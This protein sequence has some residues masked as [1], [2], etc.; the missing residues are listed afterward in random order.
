M[1]GARSY[2]RYLVAA[3][4]V[5]AVGYSQGDDP[6]LPQ[7]RL[8]ILLTIGFLAAVITG[9]LQLITRVRAARCRP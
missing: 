6:T 7:L 8:E 3:I 9:A 4:V 5:F 1:H 2:V